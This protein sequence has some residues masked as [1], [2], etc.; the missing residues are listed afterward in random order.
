MC[1]TTEFWGITVFRNR[2]FIFCFGI[3]FVCNDDGFHSIIS[4]EF[5]RICDPL[6]IVSGKKV[7][8]GVKWRTSMNIT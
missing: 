4:K 6:V 8:N 2:F 5:I 1:W 3:L 7:M